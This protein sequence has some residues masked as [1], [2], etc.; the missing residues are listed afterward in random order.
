MVG[1]D[2]AAVYPAPSSPHMAISQLVAK[3]PCDQIRAAPVTTDSV[4]V[5]KWDKRVGFQRHISSA[6]L[7]AT[8]AATGAPIEV[9]TSCAIRRCPAG[10]RPAASRDMDL[11]ALSMSVT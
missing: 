9:T 2:E 8:A 3:A 6:A 7:I 11:I 10:V 5:S 1:Y 4:D